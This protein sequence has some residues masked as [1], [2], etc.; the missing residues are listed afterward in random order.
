MSL[1]LIVRDLVNILD[2]AAYGMPAPVSRR[3]FIANVN[4]GVNGTVSVA[5]VNL[6]M[7]MLEYRHDH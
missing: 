1:R 3:T 2:P 7:S 4:V 6:S 5:P